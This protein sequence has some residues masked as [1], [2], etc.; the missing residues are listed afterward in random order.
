MRKHWLVAV[1]VAAAP[2]LAEPVRADIGL[3]LAYV[4]LGSPAYARFKSFVDQAVGGNPGYAF[5]ATDAVY[6]YKLTGQPQYATLAISWVEDQVTAAEAAIASS[7]SP[8]IAGDSYL[9]VGGM[10][11]DVAL[12]YD[13]CYPLL[14]PT[15]RTRWAAYADQAVFNVWNHAT[16]SWG[17]HPFPW[18]GWSVDNPGNNYHYSFLEA[19]MYWGFAGDRQNWIDYL[20]NTKLPAL[21]SYFQALPGGG[22]REGT[23]YGVALGRLFEIYRLWK[24]STPTHADLGAQSTHLAD[25]LDYWIHGTVPTLDRYAPI[26][27]LSRESYPSLYDY[28]RNLVLEARAMTA[29]PGGTAVAARASWWLHHIA[30]DEMTSGFNFRDD[31]LPAGSTQTQPTALFHHATGAG[32]LFARRS[33]ATDSPWISFVAGPYVESHAHQ[34]QGAFNY[35]HNDWLAVTENIWSHSGIE[36]GTEIHNTLR[37]LNGSATIPQTESTSS[38]TV[39]DSAGVLHVAANLTPAYASSG[40]ISNWQRALDFDSTSLTVTDNW[41]AA[42]G[43]TAVFQVNVPATPS[44]TAG[45]ITAG[46]LRIRPITPANPA[47]SIVNWHNVDTEEFNSGYKVELRGGTGTYVVRLEY[48]GG[49]FS[50]GFESGNFNAWD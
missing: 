50:N 16:A 34:D 32:H 42:G 45:V 10:L 46:A 13:W 28:H 33:W 14:T 18:S 48:L 2:L 12:V 6:M 8:E 49:L 43:V 21:V 37:F 24:D 47:I 7:Q 31:L 27:D 25:T 3:S 30:V 23:G 17:G 38:M 5:S 9:A 1:F 44:V 35:F 4:D 11:R 26:G 29:A 22:S 41:S 39:S 19:T 20:A 15:Q 36:Q 40:V